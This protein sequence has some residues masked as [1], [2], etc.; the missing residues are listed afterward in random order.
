MCG[1]CV[2]LVSNAARQAKEAK[3]IKKKARAK[4]RRLQV[5]SGVVV[6]CSIDQ[7]SRAMLTEKAH[8]KPLKGDFPCTERGHREKEGRKQYMQLGGSGHSSHRC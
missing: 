6:K 7:H 4:G 1:C 8:V 5:R 3:V 2:Q